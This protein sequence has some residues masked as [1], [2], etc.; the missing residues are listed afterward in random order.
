MKNASAETQMLKAMNVL[1]T[2]RAGEGALIAY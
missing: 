1:R 2:R